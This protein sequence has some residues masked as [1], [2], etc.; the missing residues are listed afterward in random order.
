MKECFMPYGASLECKSL[1][2]KIHIIAQLAAGDDYRLFC[3]ASIWVV[4]NF[5]DK[6]DL[7]SIDAVIL[8]AFQYEKPQPKTA[9]LRSAFSVRHHLKYWHNLRDNTHTHLQEVEPL[10]RV[11][12]LMTG[13]YDEVR[14]AAI[15]YPQFTPRHSIWEHYPQE[16]LWPRP[17][18][19][20]V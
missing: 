4:E 16:H 8:A 12:R 15:L 2:E 3:R 9:I 6:Y 7:E 10:Y 13:L 14:N 20:K 11:R 17:K 19:W 18:W 5:K 1:D